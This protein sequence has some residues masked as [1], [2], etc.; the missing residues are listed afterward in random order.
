MAAERDEDPAVNGIAPDKQL[1]LKG[2][3]SDARRVRDFSGPWTAQTR[4]VAGFR[5]EARVRGHIIGFDEPADL[6]AEDT[7]PTP[8]S[9]S[10]PPGRLPDR[11][12][13]HARHGPGIRLHTLRIDLSGT[14]DSILR[15]AGLSDSGNPATAPWRSRRTSGATRARRSC[16]TCGTGHWPGPRRP[17]HQ[18]PHPVV[19]VLEVLDGEEES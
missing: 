3:L 18:P 19:A 7:A 8:T 9:T 13:R 14:F 6:A 12:S 15:W 11:R 17:D 4:W 1:L 16:A 5:T 10:S 2:Q